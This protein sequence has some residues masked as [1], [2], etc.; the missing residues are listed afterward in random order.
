MYCITADATPQRGT[1]R[2]VQRVYKEYWE[3]TLGFR[4]IGQ[5]ARCTTCARLAKTRR[6]SPDM[7]ERA[8]AD[9]EYKAH[10]KG[11]FAMRRVDMRFSQ[12]SAASCEPGCTLPN[13]CLHIRIDGLDQAKGRCPRN[14]E[15]SKQWSTLW[16]PQLHIVGVTVEGLF[17][18]Y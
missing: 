15:N 8:N 17:E 11:V 16:R 14:L 5:H 2:L 13:R 4:S 3:P 1:L 6:D 10:L 7:D 9:A 18:Q 12:M